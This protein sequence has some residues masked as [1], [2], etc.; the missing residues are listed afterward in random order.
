MN[1]TL[2]WILTLAII[3]G[4]L[5]RLPF[6]NGA[7]TPIDSALIIS[8]LILIIKNRFHLEK[9][10]LFLKLFLGFIMVGLFSLI[11]SPLNLTGT[12]FTNSSFYL[13]RLSMFAIFALFLFSNNTQTFRTK[14][15]NLLLI[16][17]ASLAV[18]GILQ[19]IFFPN[20]ITLAESGWDPHF[21]RTASTFLD[22]N[23]AGAFFVLTLLI[24]M[25]HLGGVSARTPRVS[26]IL[27]AIVYLALLTTFS[28]SSYLMFAVSGF[29][30]A[31]FKKSKKIAIY[32]LILFTLLILAFQIYI[33][34][35]AKPYNI[36]REQSASFRMS[37]WL[38]GLTIFQSSPILGVGYNSYRYA[39]QE[40]KLADGQFLKSHG[41][42]S[43]DSSILFVASTTGMVGL[44]IYFLFLLSFFKKPLSQDFILPSAILGL[45]VH[46]I[47]ANSLFYPPILLWIFL[48]AA[49][50]KK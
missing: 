46:S 7:I 6:G 32:V 13:V 40:Y 30:F 23:F 33:Q 18:L 3:S 37:A 14:I 19:F 34:V 48:K 31:F 49:G 50:I 21:F 20:L 43:N 12:E 39:I 16:S 15:K 11:F 22:P 1:L 9:P 25:S 4:Q 26:Y 45:F 42:S 10:P 29:S 17:G 24:V 41:S 44:T 2:T 27:F 8:S 28:R 47:F 35:I 38:Q 5:I 36:S